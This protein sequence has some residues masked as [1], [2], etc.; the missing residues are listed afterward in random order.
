MEVTASKRV[1]TVHFMIHLARLLLNHHVILRC[2]PKIEV[3]DVVNSNFVGGRLQS[4]A[5]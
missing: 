5:A 3:S 2:S 4:L 1:V